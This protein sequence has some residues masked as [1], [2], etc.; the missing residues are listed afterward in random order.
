MKMSRMILAA[1]LLVL[2]VMTLAQT[3]PP[4]P[5]D[6]TAPKM[7]EREKMRDRMMQMRKEGGGNMMGMRLRD[8]MTKLSPEGRQIMMAS[9]KEQGE[10]QKI[11]AEKLRV[12][13]DRI[14]GVMSAEKFDASALSKLFAEERSL[15]ESNQESRHKATVTALS[16]LSDADRKVFTT[17]L[18]EMRDRR[19]ERQG[20]W[21]DHKLRPNMAQPTPQ[22]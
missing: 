18:Q 7:Q 13:Q 6:T 11:N 10:R 8:V 9:M 15:S 21:S 1:S 5:G 22:N 4:Q 17:T 16:K 3:P 19:Q 20:K 14:L 2:P 12:V